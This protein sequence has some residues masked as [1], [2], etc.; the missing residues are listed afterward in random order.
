MMNKFV[1]NCTKF[2]SNRQTKITPIVIG[3][4]LFIEPIVPGTDLLSR[5]RTTIGAGGLNGCVRDG[6][7]RRPFGLWRAWTSVSPPQEAP[8]TMDSIHF[9][10]RTY[11]FEP[12]SRRGWPFAGA[13][14]TATARQWP[15]PA[16][17][18]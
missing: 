1:H 3:V 15:G 18:K 2:I 8:E 10:S 9:M 5:N 11:A 13:V 4:I 17:T 6:T 16:T 14:V 7:R 12:S